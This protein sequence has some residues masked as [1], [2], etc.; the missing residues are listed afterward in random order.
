[1]SAA[2]SD[3]ESRYTTIKVEKFLDSLLHL[4]QLDTDLFRS[5]EL[6]TPKHARGTYGGQLIAHALQ[7]AQATV[8][9]DKIVHSL[10]SNFLAAGDSASPMYYTVRRLRDGG[11]FSVRQV[12]AFQKSEAIYTATLSFQKREEPGIVHGPTLSP[13][14]KGPDDAVSQV[15]ILARLIDGAPTV[16]LKENLRRKVAPAIHVRYTNSMSNKQPLVTKE[17]MRAWFKCDHI[18]DEP[19]VHRALAFYA[20]DFTLA[21]TPMAIHGLPNPNLRM[22]VSLD[23]TIYFHRDFDVREWFVYEVHSSW[24]DSNR[25]LCHGRV[26]TRDGVLTMTVVQETLIR[27]KKDYRSVAKL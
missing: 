17:P 2:S 20:T 25:G 16:Q 13:D 15:D 24:A 4:E 23:H 14:V 11:A 9:K 12:T 27:M 8:S 10:R 7:A 26:F 1:M 18:P 21:L 6:V 3:G 22:I 5:K 19:S